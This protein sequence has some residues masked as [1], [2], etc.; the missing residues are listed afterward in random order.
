[1]KKVLE[2]TPENEVSLVNKVLGKIPTWAPNK[3]IDCG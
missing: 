1:M 3:S 2:E